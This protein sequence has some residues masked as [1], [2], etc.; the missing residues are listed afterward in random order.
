MSDL[1]PLVATA[2]QRLVK[3]LFDPGSVALVGVSDDPTKTTG[4]ALSFL[5]REEFAGAVFPVNSGRTHVQGEP[6]W[7][8]LSALPEVPDHVFVM[9]GKAHVVEVCREAV[10]LGVPL[11]TVLADGFTDYDGAALA[12]QLRAVVAGSQTRV[13]GPSSLGV[14]N[15]RNGLMLTANAAFA[16]GGLPTGRT[17][18]VSQSGS[19]IGGLPSRGAALGVGFAA[20]VSVGS[21]LDL[22]VG[23]ICEATLD[24]EGID[25]YVLF[26]E[27]LKGADRIRHFAAEALRRN[28]PVVAYKLGRSEVGAELARSHTGALAGAEEVS[29]QFFA[30]SGIARVHS[31][32]GLIEGA[33]LARKV[34]LVDTRR[35]PRVGVVTST[36]GGAAMVVDQLGVLGID[37]HQPSDATFAKLAAAGAPA[38][39]GRIVDLTLSGASYEVMSAAL[40]VLLEARE[41][42]LLVVV[43]GSSARLGP[44][45]TVRPIIERVDAAIPLAAFVVPEAPA[46]LAALT[47]AGVPCFRSPEACAD[48][49]AAVLRRRPRTITEGRVPA[50]ESASDQTVQLDEATAYGVLDSMGVPHSDFVVIEGDVV[51]ALPFGFPVV[52]KVLSDQLAHKSDV[53]GVVLGIADADELSAAVTRIRASVGRIRPDVP[54]PAILVQPMLSGE[55]EV[56]VGYR[57]DREVG[58]VVVVAAGGQLAELYA[59]RSI[60]L[61]PVDPVTALEMIGEVRSL[62]VLDGF[63]GRVRGD[64]DALVD[65]IVQVS[66]LA[67]DADVDELEINPLIVKEEGR[68]VVA[69]DALIRVAIAQQALQPT[70]VGAVGG[71]AT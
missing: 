50:R 45:T 51:P 47:A 1:R 42:D 46:A 5:R 49:I 36:G 69:V 60:R 24:L 68:G 53:G 33:A 15:L 23:E 28:R 26:L 63:R 65:A 71:G 48:A 12:E 29:A 21:E 9:V 57:V 56:L 58:P 32:D 59:D 40:D 20:L 13:I 38:K 11:L 22:S 70:A 64:V 27:S 44:D 41:H 19:L 30:D 8:S 16:E 66:R 62:R 54:R 3:A 6:A 43:A 61:A 37:V 2:S 67:M 52:A 31:L 10:G 17:L 35:A 34:P 7:P 18:V 4:R 25:S 14:V 39:T 55:T